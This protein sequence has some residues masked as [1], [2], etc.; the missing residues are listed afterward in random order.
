MDVPESIRLFFEEAGWHSGRKVDVDPKVPPDHPVVDVLQAFDGLDV[1]LARQQSQDPSRDLSFQFEAMDWR[2]FSGYRKA[3]QLGLVGF[4]TAYEDQ[5]LLAMDVRGWCYA[6]ALEHDLFYFMGRTWAEAA[7][8]QLLGIDGL[9]VI[10]P[11][12]TTTMLF[13]KVYRPGDPNLVDLRLRDLSPA[14]ISLWTKIS[15]IWS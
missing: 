2:Y 11:G 8:R 5:L 9:P 13:G 1:T 7:E 10:L 3:K 6:I 4:A 15:R 12:Q 14:Q